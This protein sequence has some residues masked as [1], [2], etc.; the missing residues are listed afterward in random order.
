MK[1]KPEFKKIWY[2][3]K[4]YFIYKVIIFIFC[5]FL[6]FIILNILFP[7]PDERINSGYSP[8]VIFPD[9]KINYVA[10]SQ[11]NTL[12]IYTPPEKIPEI[13]KKAFIAS[14]DRWFYYHPGINPVSIIRA[15]I[16]NIKHRRIVSGGS[17]ITMQIAR[18][19]E[20]RKRNI[21]S[22]IIEAFRALQLELKYSKE[23]LLNIYLN[24]IPMG[25][26]LEGIGSA[27]FFYFNKNPD[28][29]SIGE[30]AALIGIPR[31]PNYARPDLNNKA[32]EKIKK[33]IL[34]ILLKR[35]VIT[36][37]EYMSALYAKL[38]SRR[39]SPPFIAPHLTLK[40]IKEHP[41]KRNIVITIDRAKQLMCENIIKKYRTKL[42]KMGIKNIAVLVVNN[43]TGK[44]EVWIGNFGY[45]DI[46]ENKIDCVTIKRSPG[47]TLKP[48]IY[49]KAIDA[50]IITP[51][52]II[53]DVKRYYAGY[54]V[55]NY[56]RKFHGPVTATFALTS[57]LNSP[58]VYLLSKL[59][60]GNI[61]SILQS[62]GY[63]IEN[64]N[65]S[66]GL[67][68]ALGSMEISLFDLVKNYTAFANNG[69][70]LNIHYIDMD[71]NKEGTKILSKEAAFLISEMLAQ[72]KRLDLPKSWEFAFG[73]SKVAWKTGTS[74]GNYDALCV[75]YNPVYT[76]GVW[77]GNA[78]RE[79]SKA[80]VGGKI[81]API[82]FEIFNALNYNNDVWF[83]KP[84]GVKIR[85]VSAASG[86]LPTSLT[87]YTIYDYYIPGVSPME[88]CDAYK[89]YYIDK[90]TGYA[91]VRT[92]GRKIKKV[93]YR[94]FPPEAI[95]WAR[96][97]LLNYKEPPP[98][99]PE[100]I[101]FLKINEKLKIVSPLYN[102]TYYLNKYLP[103]SN[104]KI[105][106]VVQPFPDT[107]KLYWFVNGKL[108]M[109]GS[110]KKSYY[111]FPDVGKYEI[112]CV[113][114]K[115]RSGRVK[116]KI[117]LIK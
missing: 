29:L 1:L 101:K 111:L 42:K 70:T 80:L 11:Y 105:P 76:I 61:I 9:G 60:K 39:F 35:G 21:I 8:T 25:G 10:L 86:K 91:V 18:M 117:E 62:L 3:I 41:E 116:F 88:K 115:G 104:Q 34:K 90:K 6:I 107:K 79:S 38:P 13:I 4:K 69:R 54:F 87:P 68:V 14:E 58:A 71:L 72:G 98:Y 110:V 89:L 16:Q 114:D 56:D 81:A 53:Y 93:V 99:A 75:G 44:I 49:G 23:E 7:L 30:I 31:A 67:S 65:Q 102:T 94:V 22:K 19:L 73:K 106:L 112:V 46:D 74:F 83:E 77:V 82:F 32:A 96:K 47:S 15:L 57:S 24:M 33:K 113:D 95:E 78:S 48:F 50:G 20:R 37:K 100:E 43:K 66:L 51:K 17:T 108:L 59:S 45:E 5:L 103:Y 28:G 52:Y 63:Q 55:R 85:K 84:P 36:K 64:F 109:K 97:N 26:N 2:K 40:A 12:R 27:A 92:N